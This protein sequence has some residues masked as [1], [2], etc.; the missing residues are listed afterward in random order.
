MFPVLQRFSIELLSQLESTGR[1]AISLST[2]E[3]RKI[4][5]PHRSSC[6][7]RAAFRHP[8]LQVCGPRIIDNYNSNGLT[9]SEPEEPYEIRWAYFG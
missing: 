7:E 5:F 1:G 8:T 6:Q 2:Q 9:S 4:V 3:P